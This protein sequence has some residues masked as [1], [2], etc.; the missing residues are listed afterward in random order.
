[1][2]PPDGNEPGAIP[3]YSLNSILSTIAPDGGIRFM[4]IDCEASEFPILFSCN[5]L[6]KVA[7]I[8]GEYHLDRTGFEFPDLPKPTVGNLCRH[9]DTAGF[10]VEVI[11]NGAKYG[12]FFATRRLE[13]SPAQSSVT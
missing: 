7:Q 1:M 12:Y 10:D 13:T 8:A 9:L 2:S 5:Q 3:C 6:H 4:K 11:E